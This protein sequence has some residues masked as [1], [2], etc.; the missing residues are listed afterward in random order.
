[1][2]NGR[3]RDASDAGPSHPVL[4][5]LRPAVHRRHWQEVFMSVKATNSGMSSLVPTEIKACSAIRRSS[6]R[7]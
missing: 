1:M 7:R 2:P 5:Y 4:G 6:V 3:Q